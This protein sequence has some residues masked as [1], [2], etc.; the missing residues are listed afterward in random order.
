[1]GRAGLR[2]RRAR[3]NFALLSPVAALTLTASLFWLVRAFV[4]QG[5]VMDVG[6]SLFFAAVFGVGAG[7]A[8]M[9]LMD[10][11]GDWRINKARWV[12]EARLIAADLEN[13]DCG[14]LVES[15]GVARHRGIIDTSPARPKIRPFHHDIPSP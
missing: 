15:H 11:W 2:F 4:F 5:D 13:G 9:V 6:V 14:C 1:M 3:F 10:E 12:M 8:G 7:Y